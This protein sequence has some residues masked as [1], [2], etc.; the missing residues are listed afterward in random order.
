MES[1][2]LVATLP[3]VDNLDEQ[4]ILEVLIDRT[5]PDIP[6]E[7]RG[8]HY[9]LATPFRYPPPKNGSRFRWAGQTQGV[10][11]A[12][13][14]PETAVA[15]IAFYKLLFFSE[16]PATPLPQKAMEHTGFSVRL[17]TER[18]L[19]LTAPPLSGAEDYWA[20]PS[21]YEPCQK[22]AD[23]AREAQAEVLRFRSVR[24]AEGRK[25]LA[26][27]NP[28]AFNS[29]PE[30]FQTWHIHIFRDSTVAIREAPAMQLE[31]PHRQFAKDERI[32][33]LI[34]A[35]GENEAVEAG[36]AVEL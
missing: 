26:V 7:F 3:L 11:Y 2:Y 30:R 5:K 31:F 6:Q 34:S 14:E 36:A 29:S 24:D 28:S 8:L 32:A 20:H 16:S 23:T 15:E 1:Q 9:L 33:G 22:F 13:E 4:K 18:A 10:F 25:N 17:S 27:L 35:W 19:D 12:A 21:N